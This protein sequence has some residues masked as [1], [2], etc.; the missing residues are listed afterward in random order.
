LFIIFC[1]LASALEELASAL[2]SL[3]APSKGVRSAEPEVLELLR[4]DA[5]ADVRRRLMKAG[6]DAGVKVL[7]S[8]VGGPAL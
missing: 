1:E 5:S 2:E 3:S 6:E 4:M 7:L 8:R